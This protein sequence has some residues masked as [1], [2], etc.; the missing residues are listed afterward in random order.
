MIGVGVDIIALSRMRSVLEDG[1]EP[2]LAKAFTH[3]ERRRAEEDAN[4]LA[5]LGMVFAAKE[6]V[7]KA[8]ATP[9]IHS[10][11]LS[12]I[13]VSDGP[14]GEPNVVLSGGFAALAAE[15]RVTSVMLSLSFDGDYA[16][17]VAALD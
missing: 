16:I 6:A 5:R 14:A 11:S 2:F 17:A 1:G 12:D 10:L 15:R 3:A 7:F 13:E 8:F 9:W 4:P